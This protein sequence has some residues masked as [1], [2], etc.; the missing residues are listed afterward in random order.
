MQGETGS[1]LEGLA[2]GSQDKPKE[3]LN[4]SSID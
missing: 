2:E 3:D 4:Q 1:T